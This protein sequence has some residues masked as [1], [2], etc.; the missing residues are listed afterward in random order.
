MNAVNGLQ[1][2]A[3]EDDLTSFLPKGATAP[4]FE[5]LHAPYGFILLE[6]KSPMLWSVVSEDDYR[7]AEAQRRNRSRPQ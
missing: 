6:D 5:G 1:I 3:P 2:L 4:T 7:M